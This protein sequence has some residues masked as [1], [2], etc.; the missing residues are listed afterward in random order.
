MKL[1][2]D[3]ALDFLQSELIFNKR[4]SSDDCILAENLSE[5]P[6]YSFGMEVEKYLLLLLLNN[7]PTIE[8]VQT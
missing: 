7:L 3:L 5:K 6:K 2:N 1:L 8:H 4:S